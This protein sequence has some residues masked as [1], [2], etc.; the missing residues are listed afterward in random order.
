[1][2]LRECLPCNRA[3]SPIGRGS[4]SFNDYLDKGRVAAKIRRAGEYDQISRYAVTTLGNLG[5]I[6]NGR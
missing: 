6:G 4:K 5:R 3:V 2:Y 1:M